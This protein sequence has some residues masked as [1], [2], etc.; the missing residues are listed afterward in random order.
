MAFSF[1]NT[2]QI[3]RP[4]QRFT[5]A[6]TSMLTRIFPSTSRKLAYRVFFH[7]HRGPSKPF[8][9][10]TPD[11]SRPMSS[12]AGVFHVHE[13]GRGNKVAV[14]SHGWADASN[15]FQPMIEKLLQAGFKVVAVDHV[16]HG[17]SPGKQSHLFAFMEALELV[18][19]DYEHAG[20]SV[21]LLVGHSM[22]GL[23][24]MN[25]PEVTLKDAQ[26]VLIAVPVQFFSTMMDTVERLGISRRM[27][28]RVLDWISPK[29]GRTWQELDSTH[30]R[31]KLHDN[32]WFVHDEQDRY[33]PF[34]D[35][36]HYAR[37][38][39]ARLI[40]TQGLG[41]RRILR[42]NGVIDQIITELSTA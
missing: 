31:S 12:Q 5:L 33:A 42:D 3:S 2:Y 34:A 18:I 7:P 39:P 16:A 17:L 41:H 15:S 24:I 25:L 20:D 27:I 10:V 8:E 4:V 6:L 30:Q 19:A 37:A 36:Q 22:G 11:A 9:K 32:V 13:F 21:E 14:L 26:V 38:L 29:Y 40:R 23:A 28:I 1:F 35:M